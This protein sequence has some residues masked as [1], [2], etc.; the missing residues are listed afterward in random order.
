MALYA[1]SDRSS[2]SNVWHKKR[3]KWNRRRAEVFRVVETTKLPLR[4]LQSESI[5]HNWTFY[6]YFNLTPPARQ[7]GRETSVQGGLKCRDHRLRI[8]RR[9][10]RGWKAECKKLSTAA[11]DR[12]SLIQASPRKVRGLTMSAAGLERRL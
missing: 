8:G 7:H 1:D 2:Q 10:Y 4:L 3:R 9:N 11:H 5:H 12:L 6:C